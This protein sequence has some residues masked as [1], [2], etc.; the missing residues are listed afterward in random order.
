MTVLEHVDIIRPSLEISETQVDTM[1][2]L[3]VE[4]VEPIIQELRQNHT[5]V[6]HESKVV[7]TTKPLDLQNLDFTVVETKVT[8]VTK[9]MEVIIEEQIQAIEI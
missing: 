9:P 3:T 4:F 6:T 7:E 5:V 2:Y 8:E 1:E